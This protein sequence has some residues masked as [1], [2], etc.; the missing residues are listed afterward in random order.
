[1]APS[2]AGRGGA[3]TD[4]LV[5]IFRTRKLLQREA[6]EASFD[7][8]CAGPVELIA[9]P[10]WINDFVANGT[11]KGQSHAIITTCLTVYSSSFSSSELA[12]GI[13]RS[14]SSHFGVH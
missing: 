2:R 12:D 13:Q 6:R 10:P 14:R 4:H 8:S 1:V 9:V 11:P 3:G 7:S 5:A